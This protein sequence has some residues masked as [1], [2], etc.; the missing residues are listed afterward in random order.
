MFP[1]RIMGSIMMH[2]AALV[3]VFALLTTNLVSA[4]YDNSADQ[5]FYGSGNNNNDN[6]NG[7]NNGNGGS[8][9]QPD[10]AKAAAASIMAPMFAGGQASLSG[11]WDGD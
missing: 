8:A 3:L 1:S 9:S 4:W 6:N 2:L 7:W 10:P 11:E 5:G